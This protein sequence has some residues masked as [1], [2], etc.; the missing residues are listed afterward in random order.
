MALRKACG[1]YPMLSL[2]IVV[3]SHLERRFAEC[4]ASDFFHIHQC[5]LLFVVLFGGGVGWGKLLIPNVR[6]CT[7]VQ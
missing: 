7:F 6:D 5:N 2:I 4:I 1:V 3:P